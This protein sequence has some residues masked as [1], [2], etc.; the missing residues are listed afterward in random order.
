[1]RQVIY[2]LTAADTMRWI[3]PWR[4]DL[5]CELSVGL[6]VGASPW[7]VS[8][9]LWEQIKPLLPQDRAAGSGPEGSVRIMFVLH[10]GIQWE[11]GRKPRHRPRDRS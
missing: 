7:I 8:D 3:G 2:A 5:A 10:T 6:V 9:G 11:P 1:M 4:P